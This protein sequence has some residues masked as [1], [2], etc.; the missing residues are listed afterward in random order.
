MPLPQG[1]PL[2]H[3]FE[4]F[5]EDFALTTTYWYVP[6]AR[7][8]NANTVQV[9][10]GIL[11]LLDSEFYHTAWTVETQNLLLDQLAERGLHQDRVQG[12]IP[13][14][15]AAGGRILL[16]LLQTLGFAYLDEDSRRITITDAGL[17]LIL[18]DTAA[19]STCTLSPALLVSFRPKSKRRAGLSNQSGLI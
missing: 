13:N 9:L 16:I 6:K 3:V 12:Q 14:D 17:S 7:A 2:R 4:Q 18:T 8:I 11:E 1:F 19:S 5:L 10:K 15:R